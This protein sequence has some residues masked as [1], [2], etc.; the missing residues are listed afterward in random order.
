MTIDQ[1][2]TVKAALKRLEYELLTGDSCPTPPAE[3][4]QVK[5][6]RLLTPAEI[7]TLCVSLGGDA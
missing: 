3:M 2:A 4:P 5:G 7:E 1:I 6:A